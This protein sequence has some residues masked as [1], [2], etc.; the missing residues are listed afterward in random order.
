LEGFSLA[1]KRI[2][3]E[4]LVKL[5]AW[6]SPTQKKYVESLD[7]GV[8]FTV[9]QLIDGHKSRFNIDLKRLYQRKKELDTELALVIN[10][11]KIREDEIREE[12]EKR[13]DFEIRK[14]HALDV[15]VKDFERHLSD[16]KFE[17]ALNFWAEDLPLSLETLRALV[18]EVAK[19]KEGQ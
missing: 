10:E 17:K 12:T 16:G 2:S 6:V 9:R 19:V 3:S 11:I 14:K 8:S 18:V 5:Q 4:D 7:Q 1:N 13:S 15:L